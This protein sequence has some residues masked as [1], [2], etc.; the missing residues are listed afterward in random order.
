MSGQAEAAEVGPRAKPKYEQRRPWRHAR[1]PEGSQGAPRDA[2][3][4]VGG[5][6]RKCLET[7]AL[8]SLQKAFSAASTIYFAPLFSSAIDAPLSKIS[9]GVLL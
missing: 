9:G 6:N 8:S 2:F 1:L 7:A 4:S 3:V 5:V